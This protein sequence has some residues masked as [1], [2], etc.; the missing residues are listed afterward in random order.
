MDQQRLKPG[1]HRRCPAG[2]QEVPQAALQVHRKCENNLYSVKHPTQPKLEQAEPLWQPEHCWS[3]TTFMNHVTSVHRHKKE[4]D[5]LRKTKTTKR[6][7][8][9][10]QT[11]HYLVMCI[12][13][14]LAVTHIEQNKKRSPLVALPDWKICEDTSRVSE[15]DHS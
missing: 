2:G 8:H 4:R 12:F 7:Q 11:R 15:K 1:R 6:N 13:P 14:R 10:F 5:T 3:E 9:F